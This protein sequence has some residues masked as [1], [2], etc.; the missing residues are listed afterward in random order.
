MNKINK[1]EEIKLL[2]IELRKCKSELYLAKQ[3][4]EPMRQNICKQ[5]KRMQIMYEHIQMCINTGDTNYPQEF[6][7]WFNRD[8]SPIL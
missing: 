4:L 3:V 7:N 1:K 5:G 8:G 6:D 2:K